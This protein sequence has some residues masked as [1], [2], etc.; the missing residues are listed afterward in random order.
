M[1]KTKNNKTKDNLGRATLKI[2]F[3]KQKKTWRLKISKSFCYKN[4]YVHFATKTP[5]KLQKS[6]GR[7]YFTGNSIHSFINSNLNWT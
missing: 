5:W 7:D 6:K 3:F 2:A 1:D 4:I